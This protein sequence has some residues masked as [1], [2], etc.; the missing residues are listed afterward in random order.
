MPKKC[1]PTLRY[2]FTMLLPCTRLHSYSPYK[3]ENRLIFLRVLLFSSF[4]PMNLLATATTIPNFLL[5]G[6]ILEGSNKNQI[7]L[8]TQEKAIQQDQV[9]LDARVFA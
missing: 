4:S 1:A 3:D 7:F 5:G 2:I 9:L 6:V 8:I